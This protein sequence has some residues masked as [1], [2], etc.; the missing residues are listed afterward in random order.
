MIQQC[1]SSFV[2]TINYKIAYQLYLLIKKKSNHN[3]LIIFGINHSGKTTLIQLLFKDIYN[4]DPYPLNNKNFEV[5][6]H[7]NYYIFNCNIITNK[8][9]FVEYLKSITQTYDY[10]NNTVKYII[11]THFESINEIIQNSIRVIIEKSSL[12]C[13]FIIVTNN[14]NKVTKPIK[15]RCTNIRIPMLGQYDKF[16]YLKQY[17]QKHHISFNELNL[18]ELCDQYTI[19]IIINKHIYTQDNIDPLLKY[20]QKIN[21]LIHEK[22]LTKKIN[23]IRTVSS[24]IKELNISVHL[25]LKHLILTYCL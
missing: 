16:I 24:E 21:Q 10:Y 19:D 25:L 4:G 6:I 23:Q 15:S 2:D 18:M 20:S 13:K 3:H 1:L 11:L 14:Y 5:L 17:F 22:N 9:E 12:V 7:P 8:S